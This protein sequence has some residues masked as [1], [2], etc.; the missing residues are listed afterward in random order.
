MS[1]DE[2]AAAVSVLLGFAPPTDSSS[3]LNEVLMPNPFDRPRAVLMLE[4]PGVDNAFLS[5]NAFGSKVVGSSKADIVLPN[6]DEVS[7]V[8]LDA[9]MSVDCDAACAEEQLGVLT[10]LL[11]GSYAG[12]IEPL[13]GELKLP[14]GSG[15][16]LNLQMTKKADRQFALN[17][18]SLVRNIYR[19]AEIH[20]DFSGSPP[21]PAELIIGRFTGIKE[22]K[23]EYGSGD[24][25]DKA[26]ELFQITLTKSLELL[27]KIYEGKI[28]GVI[29]STS[30][31]KR[32]SEAIF[33]VK[34][35]TQSS[36]RLVEGPA[37]LVILEI[38]L[39]RR[40]LA[41]I[42]ALILLISTLIGVRTTN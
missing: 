40:S 17:L 4:V 1:P 25:T 8:A 37:E 38:L 9:D 28:V 12:S 27:Q 21:N 13:D 23:E 35:S 39:V 2:V 29:L 14:L 30:E 42:T 18:V 24:V 31:P 33:D 16:S 15:G 10:R 7:V 6:E 41:L 34:F 19:A 36:R 3:K 11:G 32:D 22:L 20:E 26:E 5:E